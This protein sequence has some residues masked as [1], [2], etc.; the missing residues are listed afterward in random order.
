MGEKKGLLTTNDLN[1]FQLLFKEVGSIFPEAKPCLVHGDL[2][3]GNF[4]GNNELGATLIDPAVHHSFFETDLAFTYLFGGFDEA[5]YEG[6]KSVAAI[7]DGF[8][9]RKNI[10]NLYPLLLH[11][12]LFGMSYYSRINNVISA[13]A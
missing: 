4:I 8:N 11:L 3:S 2:W 6:Y 1:A 7:E 12:N 13:F 9:F 10:Y 5:F